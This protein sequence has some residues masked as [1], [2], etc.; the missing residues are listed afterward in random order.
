GTH[1]LLLVIPALNEERCIGTVVRRAREVLRG[2]DV[3]VIDDGSTDGTRREAEK[4][5]A[6]VVSHPFNLG[7]G[8][9]VQTGLKF[10][11]RA[12]YDFVMRIDADGQH[13]PAK[14]EEML[15]I[16]RSGRA[17]VAIGSR[18]LAESLDMK[19]SPVRRIGIELFRWEVSVITGRRVT[20]T[21]SGMIVL[22]RRAIGVLA[23]HMPQDYPEVEM[24][25]ILHVAGLRTEEVAVRMS[26]RMAGVSSIGSWNSFYYAV[27]VSIAV[28]LTAI[29]ESSKLRILADTV[30]SSRPL[31]S[32]SPVVD[33]G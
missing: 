13:D 14:L 8:G 9:A 33:P 21:T 30:G 20:D 16:V 6:I 1:S 26:E 18:F 10:A 12:G 15:S 22:N 28:V 31:P 7:I 2:A 27:K 32:I 25:I 4:A 24:R 5:G 29:K 11:Q 19:I 3:L 23:V 17:D